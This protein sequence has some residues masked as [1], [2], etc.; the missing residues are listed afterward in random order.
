MFSCVFVVFLLLSKTVGG[1]EFHQR[2]VEP[3]S[4]Y[5]DASQTRSKPNFGTIYLNAEDKLKGGAG[6]YVNDSGT[7][8][9]CTIHQPQS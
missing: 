4:I 6:V 9:S 2:K 3:H 1:L 7:F 5:G 8:G